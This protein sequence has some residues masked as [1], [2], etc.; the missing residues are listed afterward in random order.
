MRQKLN[1][2]FASILHIF[3]SAMT[4]KPHISI[5]ATI[6]QLPRLSEESGAT[7]FLSESIR[8]AFMETCKSVLYWRQLTY[9]YK[10]MIFSAALPTHHFFFIGAFD[11]KSLN[12]VITLWSVSMFGLHS[13]LSGIEIV[14]RFTTLIHIKAYV[15]LYV[16]WKSFSVD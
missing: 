10:F 2:K 16:L 11:S 12:R 4:A 7:Y 6:R 14:S 8:P 13:L 3:S 9:D 5:W 1:F 15:W